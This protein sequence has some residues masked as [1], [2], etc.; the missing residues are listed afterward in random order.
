MIMFPKAFN[1]ARGWQSHGFIYCKR[2]WTRKNVHFSTNQN[3]KDRQT[4]L[5]GCRGQNG[6]D[7]EVDPTNNRKERILN[8]VQNY[9]NLERQELLT[10]W[11]IPE[12]NIVDSFFKFILRLKLDNITCIF[13]FILFL[14][15]DGYYFLPA[16]K[17]L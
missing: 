11:V 15:Y 16:W 9:I 2:R 4:Q 6:L 3:P 13:M 10:E 17:K 14:N 8:M 5:W 1:W 12:G 7:R